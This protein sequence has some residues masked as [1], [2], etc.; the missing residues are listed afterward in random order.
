MS[1][2]HEVMEVIREE[3]AKNLK[4]V[5][6]K[7]KLLVA[8]YVKTKAFTKAVNNAVREEIDDLLFG[9]GVLECLSEREVNAL[10]QKAIRSILR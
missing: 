4:P 2:E 9:D 8:E 7:I 10:K 1:I 5:R 3:A 6:E